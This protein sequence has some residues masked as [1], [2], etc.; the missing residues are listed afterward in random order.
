MRIKLDENLPDSLSPLLKQLGHDASTVNDEG[1]TGG[2]D[3]EIWEAA[4]REARF[5]IT[6]DLDFSDTRQFAPGR[7]RGILLVRLHSPS[8]QNL[9]ERVESIF[10]SENI[11]GWMGCFVVA[12]ERKVRVQKPASP[13]DP[14]VH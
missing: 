4:Q 1:L 13:S 12:T 7:H 9:I 11:E 5:L 14:Q 6:Q 10:R 3:H 2:A 8:R